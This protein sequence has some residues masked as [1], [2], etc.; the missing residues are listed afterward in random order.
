MKKV[1][2]PHN[3]YLLVLIETGIVGFI[4]F[5]SIF[6]FAWVGIKNLNV[7]ENRKIHDYMKGL[8]I[9]FAL[10]CLLNSLLLDAGEGKFFCLMVGLFLSAQFP[11]ARAR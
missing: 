7:Q 4:L 6:Y 1:T 8:I 9:T 10:G 3:Q 5:V 11:K 2:N